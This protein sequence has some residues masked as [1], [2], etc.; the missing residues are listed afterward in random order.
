MPIDSRRLEKY[1]SDFSSLQRL[2]V[3]RKITVFLCGGLKSHRRDI[4][5]EYL[6]I[7]RKWPVFFADDVWKILAQSDHNAL[8]MENQLGEFSNVI[9]IIAES[10]G[11][12]AEIGAFANVS[13]LRE[14]LLIIV[15]RKFE[16]E[17]SFLNTGPLRWIKKDSNFEGVLYV[18]FDHFITCCELVIQ[19]IEKGMKKR[20]KKNDIYDFITSKDFDDISL[21]Y[22]LSDVITIFG[23][24]NRSDIVH[25]LKK[26]GVLN[27]ESR[28][29]RLLAMG[30]SMKFYMRHTVCNADLYYPIYLKGRAGSV[31][32]FSNGKRN[33]LKYLA[34]AL[35]DK[36]FKEALILSNNAS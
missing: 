13:N 14:K 28:V 20:K 8:G 5:A 31:T 33:R 1:L 3:S 26:I 21:I 17:D 6:R 23:P 30:V 15:D 35:K 7:H 19:S 32:Y 11:T 29:E 10:P 36:N 9:I 18:D 4:L 24:C 12:F 34:K 22:L 25:V 16:S 2:W 27:Y